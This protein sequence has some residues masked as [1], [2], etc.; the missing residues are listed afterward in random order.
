VPSVLPSSTSTSSKRCPS[1]AAT[2]LRWN[3]SITPTSLKT[4]ATTLTSSD[5]VSSAI[6]RLG[7]PG[8][9]RPPNDA[10]ALL[11]W[12]APSA[13]APGRRLRR[14]HPTA[15]ASA[16]P[17]RANEETIQPTRQLRGS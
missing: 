11:G 7:G 10:T 3:S 13:R 2:T 16:S 15:V 12:F 8:Y 6:A 17:T 14:R 5:V 9:L 4:G 1:S